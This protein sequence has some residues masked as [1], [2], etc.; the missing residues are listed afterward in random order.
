MAIRKKE[1]SLLRIAAVI[2][3][4]PVLLGAYKAGT[5]QAIFRFGFNYL[6]DGMNEVTRKQREKLEAGKEQRGP[7]R[8]A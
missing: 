4:I 5:P 1:P 3:L 7:A 8:K 6:S 2:V